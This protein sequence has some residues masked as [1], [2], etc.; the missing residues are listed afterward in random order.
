MGLV[1]WLGQMMGLVMGCWVVGL[2]GGGE[3][4]SIL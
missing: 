1:R 2:L 3:K 4:L